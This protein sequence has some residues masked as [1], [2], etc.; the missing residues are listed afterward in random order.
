MPCQ[1]LS[2]SECAPL[3]F[4]FELVT[5]LLRFVSIAFL[6]CSMFDGTFVYWLCRSIVTHINLIG[7]GIAFLGVCW[8]NHIKRQR[9]AANAANSAKEV[10]SSAPNK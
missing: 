6:T 8:Y 3:L 9:D 5:S 2:S 10:S 7:Y 1:W 4:R